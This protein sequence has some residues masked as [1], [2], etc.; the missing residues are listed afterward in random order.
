M[1]LIV[2]ADHSLKSFPSVVAGLRALRD[3][4]AAELEIV[5]LTRSGSDDAAAA[6]GQ[7]GLADLP[8]VAGSPARYGDYNVRVM[9]F[10]IFVGSD[11]IV[12]ASSLV[13]HDWQVTK[14]WQVAQIPVD[15]DDD[16][17]LAA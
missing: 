1:Q 10:A 3:R 16:A 11:G 15:A 6:V 4:V 7:L 8:V 17:R 14:L 2:F 5:I 12:R 13:N 9:P